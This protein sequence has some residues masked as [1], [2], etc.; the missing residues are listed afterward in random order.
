MTTRKPSRTSAPR[1]KQD[2]NLNTPAYFLSLTVEREH[3]ASRRQVIL[4]NRLKMRVT[5]AATTATRSTQ[6]WT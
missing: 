4:Q 3:D 6:T 2:A 1:R 5:T